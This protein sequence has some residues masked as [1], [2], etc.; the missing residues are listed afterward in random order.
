MK[1][2][3]QL[4][5]THFKNEVI[6]VAGE[7]GYLNGWGWPVRNTAITRMTEGYE[8]AT[9]WGTKRMEFSKTKAKSS[10]T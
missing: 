1:W 7:T 6:S 8:V 2:N 10:A 3:T 9:L 5:Y 4:T